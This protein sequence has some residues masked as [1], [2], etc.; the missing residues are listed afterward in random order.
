MKAAPSTR[1]C[2]W[3]QGSDRQERRGFD[4][5][6]DPAA[7]FQSPSKR[8]FFC[9]S[10]SGV[11]M[12]FYSNS[13][14]DHEVFVV[15]YC[16]DATRIVGS[17]QE[18]LQQKESVLLQFRRARENTS[19]G[20]AQFKMKFH[21]DANPVLIFGVMMK[22]KVDLSEEFPEILDLQNVFKFMHVV[23]LLEWNIS[24]ATSAQ[25][26]TFFE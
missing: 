12:Q 18:C 1:K 11:V 8:Q 19:T 17:V 10:F 2:L 23:P 24:I 9:Q 25:S 4:D 16:T 21:K 3:I 20:L 26:L 5:N 6:L 22:R 7:V 15:G 14:L 13:N